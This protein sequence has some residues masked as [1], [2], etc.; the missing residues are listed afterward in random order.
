MIHEKAPLND[1]IISKRYVIPSFPECFFFFKL[2]FLIFIIF[3]MMSQ[4]Y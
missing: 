3:L 4:N 1:E 2:L